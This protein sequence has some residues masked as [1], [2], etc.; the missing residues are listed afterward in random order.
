MIFYRRLNIQGKEVITLVEK[1]Q[2]E[3]QY[4]YIWNGKDNLG[5]EINSGVYLGVLK[6]NKARQVIKMLLVE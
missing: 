5:N 4:N 1:M 3:G 2:A 6:L